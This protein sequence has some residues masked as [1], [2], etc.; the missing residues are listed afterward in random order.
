MTDAITGWATGQGRSGPS[1]GGWARRRRLGMLLEHFPDLSEMR[2]VDL[3]GEFQSWQ[4][5]PARPAQLV[6]VNTGWQAE[7]SQQLAAELGWVRNVVGDACDLPDELRGE[8]FDLV[9]S[10]SVIEHVGGHARRV[11]FADSVHALGDHHWIQTPNRY[12]PIEP[13][14]LF[15]GAQFLPSGV[16]AR[17]IRRWPVG[18]IRYALSNWEWPAPSHAGEVFPVE[19]GAALEQAPVYHTLRAILSIELLTA[20]EL[21]FYF[22]GSTVVRERVAGIPKSII[23]VR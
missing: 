3:G 6:T 15:P 23:A 17:L 8:R 7:N 5:A 14:M 12:F 10:N 22:P 4:Q 20:A 13:H 2:V 18:H 21:G 19:N 1:L 9:F 11:A 16:R